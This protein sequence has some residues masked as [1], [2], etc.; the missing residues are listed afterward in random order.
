VTHTTFANRRPAPGRILG[1]LLALTLAIAGFL[2]IPSRATADDDR[3]LQGTWLLTVTVYAP[4][5]PS[6]TTPTF[7]FHADHTLNAT[8]PLDSTGQP[9]YR[10]V[11]FWTSDKDGAITFYITHPGRSD[12]A[13]VGMVQAIHL[14]KLHGDH[15][16]T[17]ADAFVKVN[18]TDTT[19]IGPVNVTS[20]GQKVSDAS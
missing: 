6:V 20:D 17:H 16:D 8:G 18:P 9:L 19:Y 3:T 10:A 14:G 11:G 5:G 13:I 15:F 4:S 12:G 1:V 7:V 2:A